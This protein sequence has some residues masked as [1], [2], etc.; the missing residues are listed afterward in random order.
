MASAG[1]HDPLTG[2]A[3]RK[4]L[5]ERADELIAEAGD[6]HTSVGFIVIG[7]DRFKAIN[8]SLG[9]AAGDQVLKIAASRLKQSTRS[10]DIV[11]RVG[12]DEF[13]IVFPGVTPQIGGINLAEKLL[14]LMRQP[15]YLQTQEILLTASIGGAFYPYDA[16]DADSLLQQATTALTKAKNRGR[17]AYRLY[18][19]DMD[20]DTTTQLKFELDLRRA[21]E[22]GQLGL[23]YQ[24]IIDTAS[25]K[26]CMF[27]ALLRWPHPTKGLLVPDKFL[28]LAHNLGLSDKIDEWVVNHACHQLHDWRQRFGHDVGLAVNLSADP[29]QR[30]DLATFVATILDHSGLEP[31][32]LELEVTEHTAMLDFENGLRTM[33][34]LKELGIDLAIDD[35]GTGYSSFTNLRRFPVDK[36]KIDKSFV[37]DLLID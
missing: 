29:F 8:E 25:G 17:N 1:L 9:N 6:E 12:A 5:I 19:P 11:A 14:E 32:A 34:T 7:L 28:S 35:F 26:V 36:I 27:E 18:S 15:F 24:P 10:D 22:R 13:S 2:L 31:E 33:H 16:E 21:V 3:N 20:S 23:Y 30:K 4:L 37:R